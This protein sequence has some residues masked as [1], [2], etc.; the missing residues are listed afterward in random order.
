MVKVSANNILI[1]CG[2]K[3]RGVFVENFPKKDLKNEYFDVVYR[4][5]SC[6]LWENC[7]IHRLVLRFFN[8]ANEKRRI[9]WLLWKKNNSFFDQKEF[10]SFQFLRHVN[11]F[12]LVEPFPL[13]TKYVS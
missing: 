12:V 11:R 8:A 3:K 6:F 7:T 2:I 13:T 4:G 9:R 1:N 5:S 10:P